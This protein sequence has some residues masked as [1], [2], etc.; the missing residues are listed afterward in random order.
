MM[1]SQAVRDKKY[2][3]EEFA[4]Q[5]DAAMNRYD[6]ET[7]VKAVYEKL[8]PEDITGKSLL[9]DGCGTGWFSKAACERGARVTSL[10]VGEKLLAEVAR[11]CSSTCVVGD[12]LDLKFPDATFDIVVSSE[13]IE[14]TTDP[15]K[16]TGEMFRVLKPGGI[17][18]L[19][20]PNWS[21]KWSVYIA[22]ALKL[23]PYQGY[24][25][26]PGYVEL[27]KW[28]RDHGFTVEMHF[29][30]HLLPFQ[31]SLLHPLLG[32]MDKAGGVLGPVMINQAIRARKPA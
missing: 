32:L 7:R 1:E 13:M 6:L 25:N 17:L 15:R 20:C 9:D 12:A 22:E 4:S 19:T 27:P 3:Y 18:A 8:L 14:H 28:L 26:W 11:K 29:G 2:F 23:R 16:A 24:E 30:L 10:D 5:F 21:W 31:V